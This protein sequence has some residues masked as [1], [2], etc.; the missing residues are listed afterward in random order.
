[1]IDR[2]HILWI[3]EPSAVGSPLLGGKFSSLAQSVAAGLPVPMGF[4]ITT[5]AYRDFIAAAGLADEVRRVRA[6]ALTLRPEAIAAE[7]R[8]LIEAIHTAPL[9]PALEQAVRGAYADLNRRTG[10]TA[11]AVAVRSSGESEDL[12]GASFAGQYETYLW[13]SGADAVIAHMRRCWAGM[14]GDAVL[15]YRHEGRVIAAEGDFGICVGVQRMVQARAAGVMFTLD[16][17]TGDRSKIQIETCW[18]LGEGV[19]K[20]DVTPSQFLCD[21]V[22]LSV[23]KRTIA[24]QPEEYRF[25]A[26]AGG[27]GL[28]PIEEDRRE[29]ACVSEEEVIELATLAKTIEKQRGAPQDIEWAIAQD[30]AIAVLQ[31]R[32]ETVWS[33]RPARPAAMIASPIDH[34]LARMSGKAVATAGK[35][36]Q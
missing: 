27:V 36:G 13:I 30:G 17:L 24:A 9:P 10:E 23:L 28:Y 34:V 22:R 19:V 21:K 16:P 25:D 12:A 14:F 11:T 18:G 20:G 15:S 31:V 2:P 35:A 1:M 32:P 6:A 29:Q 26:D 33:N 7:T 5:H 3:D 8:G 4:G